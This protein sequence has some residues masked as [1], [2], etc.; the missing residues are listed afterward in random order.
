MCLWPWPSIKAEETAVEKQSAI[1]NRV[2]AT[3]REQETL[4][5]KYEMFPYLSVRIEEKSAFLLN[6]TFLDSF[7]F[8][9]Q[10]R[11]K[12]KV[13]E[14]AGDTCSQGSRAGLKPGCCNT[15]KRHVVAYSP[16]ELN[17]CS[18]F[19]LSND[20]KGMIHLLGETNLDYIADYDKIT[21]L[22]IRMV[23]F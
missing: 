12:R 22:L 17:S 13:G 5:Y 8:I 11:S 7:A 6:V 4:F 23:F 16:S 9:G 14:R 2:F 19:S 20:L 3:W 10:W 15:A 18:T 21:I 1:W